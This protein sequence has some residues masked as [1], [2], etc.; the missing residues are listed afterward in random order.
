MATQFNGFRATKP[1]V[2]LIDTINSNY[3]VFFIVY[4]GDTRRFMR[5]K[6]DINT[7]P[8]KERKA[9]AQATA[10][11]LWEALYSGWNPL[12]NKYP[13]FD[14]PATK[15]V[16][17]F[18]QALD[19]AYKRKAEHLSRYSA[20]DYAGNVRF[21]KKAAAE[22]GLNQTDITKLERKD[23]RLL[24]ATAKE[25][26]DW[27]NKSRNKHLTIL[28]ALLSVLV[29]EDLLPY[30]PAHKIKNEPEEEGAGYT[31]LTDEEKERVAT[32]VLDK[33]PAFFEYLMF[34]YQ[35]GIR[36][37]E[38]L[39]VKIGDIHLQ[40]REIRI[41]AEVAKTNVE[42]S[43]P[44]PDDL[45]QILMVREVFSL[46]KAWYLFSSNKFNPGE[47]P[48]HPNT[49]TNWWRN[50]VINGLGI[51]CKMYSLKHKGA[52]DK[53]EAG[54]DLDVLRTLYGHRSKQ[55]TEIYAKAVKNKYKEQLI[56]HSPAFAKVV[57]MQRKAQ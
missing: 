1:V 24:M 53:I 43:V 45:M 16:I 30:N 18:S 56:E 13:R 47:V 20:Y 32:E 21:M 50:I 51:N 10:N 7:L 35:D 40:R 44:I 14:A 57:K 6:K 2:R 26:N 8:T 39:Q 3:E 15:E 42:R 27:S 9:Q 37:S 34:M 19:F 52:D 41:R 17:R 5:Y 31:R 38:L 12:Q 11:A 25:Q 22:I 29:D 4:V 55:M 48:Y 46:N 49:P 54:L 23:M 33:A 28:K 36:R